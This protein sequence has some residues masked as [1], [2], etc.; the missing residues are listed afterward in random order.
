MLFEQRDILH[1]K[2]IC[3]E[4]L[5]EEKQY[6]QKILPYSSTQS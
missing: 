3:N 2:I 1:L 6:L 4:Y 5:L